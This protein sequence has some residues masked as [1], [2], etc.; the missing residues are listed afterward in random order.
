MDWT[1]LVTVLLIISFGIVAISS[2]IEVKS[3]V[4]YWEKQI[5]WAVVGFVVLVLVQTF[6]YEDLAK[7]AKVLYVLNM[8]MLAL[9]AIMGRE[10]KGAESWIN[11]GPVAIQPSE[12]AKIFVII[13]FATYLSKKQGKLRDFKDLI[14]CFI[15]V[16]IPMLFILAQPDLGTA[17]VFIAIMFG[18]LFVGGARPLH[19]IMLIVFGLS[20]AIGG[21]YL[22]QKGVVN[23]PLKE[24][25]L[26][27]LTIFTNPESDPR[28]AGYHVLQSQIA[29][30]SGGIM[31]K[32][33]FKGTQNKYDFLPEDHTDF[34]FSVI[35]EEL[36]FVGSSALLLLL[37]VLLYRG[38]RIAA[39]ARDFFGTLVA[40]G[41]VSMFMF[42]IFENVGMTVSLMPITGIPLPL[43]SYGGSS[44]L[45]NMISIGILLNIYLRRQKIMF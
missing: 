2:A 16:G 17:L 27:R 29:I 3:G 25:Q 4:A 11:L 42:H 5:L 14:P 44:M 31:G 23:L 38:I 7:G 32:G 15:H 35:G 6:H 26:K 39:E 34:I 45:T 12:F 33:L 22:H 36:G 19:L 8:L 13:T 28:G 18:M 10:V 30:G 20:V 41:I 9:V 40:T 1:L 24:H 21:V 43:V 37:F